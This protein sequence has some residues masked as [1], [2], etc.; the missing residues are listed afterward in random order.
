MTQSASVFAHGANGPLTLGQ[1][2]THIEHGRPLASPR[3]VARAKSGAGGPEAWV[4]VPGWQFFRQVVRVGLYLQERYN[5]TPGDRVV[6]SS[7]L[8]PHRLI[9]EWA[10]AVQGGVVAIV[11]PTMPGE[12]LARSLASLGARFAFV[13][14]P[15][16]HARM[17]QEGGRFERVVLFE[18]ATPS[19][20]SVTPWSRVL[21]QGGT[22]DTA[23]RAQAF[24]ASL[25]AIRA[26]M[27]AVA[28]REEAGEAASWKVLSHA[29]MVRRL[30]EL[31]GRY[32]PRVG[33]V[34]YVIDPGSSPGPRSALWALVADGHSTIAVGTP[35]REA[36]EV[37]QVAPDLVV[38]PVEALERARSVR[39]VR[40]ERSERLERTW[41]ASLLAPFAKRARAGASDA[42]R[43]PRILTLEGSP[44]LG[45]RVSEETS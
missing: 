30:T 8:A 26:E 32:S 7:P 28:Y 12:A 1:L 41:P 23:E 37:A 40:G 25:R 2:F 44:F 4:D 18:G 45:D 27:P 13:A 22:L 43:E 3:V 6:V 35:N 34:A 33:A 24:R 14:G 17:R 5:L 39:D 38:G 31:W 15:L 20:E 16:E 42:R 10:V 11:D 9:V 19:D 36:E 29:E 21:D